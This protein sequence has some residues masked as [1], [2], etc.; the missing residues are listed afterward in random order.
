MHVSNFSGDCPS[1]KLLAIVAAW[2]AIA[3]TA[4][5]AAP[6]K[7]TPA[8]EGH[9]IQWRHADPGGGGWIQAIAWDPRDPQTLYAG[10]DVGG[11][12]LSLDGGKTFE[13]RNHGLRD[14]FIESIAVHPKNSR[15]IL[16]GMESGI[17]RT[18]DQG[19]TWQAIRSGFPA[20]QHWSFSSP[21]GAVCFDPQRPR[22]AYAGIGRPRWSK[23]GQGA[24]YRSDDAGLT[25]HN[26]SAGQLPADAIVSDIHVKPDDSR[27]VLA[28]TSQ[29]LFRSGDEGQ[30]WKLSGTGLP[31]LYTEKIAFAISSPETVYLTL[32][33]TARDAQPWNGGVCRSDDAGRNWHPVNGEGLAKRVGKNTESAYMTS[34]YRELVV[35]PAQ[36]GRGLR[37]QSRLGLGRRPQDDRRRADVEAGDPQP[38]RGPKHGL[39]LDNPVRPGRGVHD[40]LAGRP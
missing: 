29:G 34:S 17:F 16:L 25:W 26:L 9:A 24:I 8:P 13:V 3:A 20:L 21:I 10:G 5:H 4:A 40:D 38:G 11:F 1:G 19:R 6:M 28:A 31:H 2:L 23:G 32:R 22:V 15:V 37:R 33:T 35:R 27:V 7:A 14:Y 30:T 12:F 39:R 18:A 36:S